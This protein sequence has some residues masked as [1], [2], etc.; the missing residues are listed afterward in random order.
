[1]RLY[2]YNDGQILFNRI[3]FAFTLI[4]KMVLRTLVYSPLLLLGWIITKQVLDVKTDK[5][6]WIAVILLFAVVF[7]FIIYFFK[8][9]LIALK[10]NKNLFWIPLFTLCVLFT[11]ILPVW[12]IFDYLKNFFTAYSEANKNLLTWIFACAFALYVYSRYHFLTN[13]APTIAY[14]Y[15]QRGIN[16][17]THLLAFS[18]TFKGRKSNDLI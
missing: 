17:T 8:G 15:Y 7:Y 13:I 1:M 9:V 16:V 18:N 3:L 5:I 6:I 14:P 11:C 2:E 10:H 12:I 4:I